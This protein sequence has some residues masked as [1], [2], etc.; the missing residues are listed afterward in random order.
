MDKIRLNNLEIYAYHGLLPE[1]KQ[2]GQKF[3]IDVASK[4]RI[5]KPV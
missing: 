5:L 3:Q 4:Q 2:L 1:E